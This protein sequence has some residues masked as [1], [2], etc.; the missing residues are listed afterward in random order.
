MRCS[1]WTASAR[2]KAWRAAD[3]RAHQ[4]SG[5]SRRDAED[6]EDGGSVGGI[7]ASAFAVTM[8]FQESQ[9]E[10]ERAHEV[11]Y[12]ATAARFARAPSGAGDGARGSS[13]RRGSS[14]AL[15]GRGTVCATRGDAS[16]ATRGDVSVVAGHGSN[17]W[18]VGLHGCGRVDLGAGRVGRE[19]RER[20]A[21]RVPL[22]AVHRL[23]VVPLTVGRGA[24][25]RRVVGPRSPST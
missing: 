5:D 4:G 18:P 1:R 3:L 23:V 9:E 19:R 14:P 17:R 11:R 2:P 10:S 16:A 8:F 6:A 24:V 13:R 15:G 21:V 12:I 7:G 25:L 20:R 22:R